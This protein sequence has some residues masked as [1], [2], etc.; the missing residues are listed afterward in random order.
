M[1]TV[2]SPRMND[3]KW[4]HVNP[5]RGHRYEQHV[6]PVPKYLVLSG[7][8]ALLTNLDT[9]DCLQVFDWKLN[10]LPAAGRKC[11]SFITTNGR[12]TLTIEACEAY[13]ERRKSL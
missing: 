6:F 7:F 11:V 8:F 13:K 2:L 1:H 9:S 12:P 5:G 4:I 3:F 10:L